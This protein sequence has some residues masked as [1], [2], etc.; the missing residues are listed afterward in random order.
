MAREKLTVSDVFNLIADNLKLPR[1]NFK[2]FVKRL[3]E[4]GINDED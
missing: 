1:Q 4:E 2:L 3:Q